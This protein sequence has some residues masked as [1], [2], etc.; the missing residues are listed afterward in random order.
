V[1]GAIEGTRIELTTY[2]RGRSRKLRDQALQG[3]KGVCEACQVDF[4]NILDGNG[5]KV[6]EVHHRKQLSEYDA[7]ELTQLKDLAVICANC[8]RLIHAKHEKPMNVETLRKL[9]R[10]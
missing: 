4:T 8:H 1:A 10:A 3:S 6:L 7:P 5:V 9:L 2:V